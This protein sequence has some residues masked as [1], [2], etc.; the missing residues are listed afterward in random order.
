MLAASVT[1]Q[2]PRR[3]GVSWGDVS[4]RFLTSAP[5]DPES[6][7]AKAEKSEDGGL[8]DDLDIVNE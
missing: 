6:G 3:S 8:G 2:K 5:A 1:K 7:Q 4:L